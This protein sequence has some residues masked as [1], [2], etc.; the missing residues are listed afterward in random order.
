MLVIELKFLMFLHKIMQKRFFG[1]VIENYSYIIHVYKI[2]GNDKKAL[3]YSS[4]SLF[5]KLRRINDVCQVPIVDSMRVRVLLPSYANPTVPARRI[6]S[7]SEIDGYEIHSVLK[8]GREVDV[9]YASQA[10]KGMQPIITD[11]GQLLLGTEKWFDSSGV[12]VGEQ[13]AVSA[14]LQ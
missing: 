3:L 11:E 1:T 2:K 10:L 8:A 9:F 12:E 5:G 7:G 13:I 6:I 14:A 4:F